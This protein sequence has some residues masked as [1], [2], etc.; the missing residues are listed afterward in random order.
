MLPPVPSPPRLHTPS[1]ALHSITEWLRYEGTSGGHLAQE[2][3]PE[4]GAQSSVQTTL[5]D[6]QGG[7][8]TACATCTAQKCCLVLRGNTLCSSWCP[9]PPVP[10][11]GT[12]EQ[13]LVLASWH[14]LF[15]DLRTLMRSP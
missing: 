3:H 14:S 6:L 13:S 4:Q 12:T 5:E 8:P 2:E 15:R 1:S 10:A 9:R 11:L 7:D